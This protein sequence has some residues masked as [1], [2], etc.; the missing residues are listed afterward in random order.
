M[1]IDAGCDGNPRA[2]AIAR[3]QR[4][5]IASHIYPEALD[6]GPCLPS[7]ARQSPAALQLWR[8]LSNRDPFYHVQW[9]N[10][11]IVNLGRSIEWRTFED[12]HTRL[13]LR[14]AGWNIERL[15]ALT[16]PG[17]DTAAQDQSANSPL[18]SGWN[19]RDSICRLVVAPFAS[20]QDTVAPTRWPNK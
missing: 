11:R 9:Q 5:N 4:Q 7:G 8:T 19:S 10:Q 2:H 6:A 20:V 15:V 16:A 12:L 14:G 1:R 17:R 13:P 3:Y 18:A